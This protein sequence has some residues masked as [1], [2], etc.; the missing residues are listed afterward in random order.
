MDSHF[1]LLP[2]KNEGSP[3][4]IAEAA[5]YGVIPITSNVG[6]ISHY[7]NESNGFVWDI[8]GPQTY[9]AVFSKAI[10]LQELDLEF[11]SKNLEEVAEL[12]TYE[13]YINKLKTQIFD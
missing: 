6:S 11:R 1:L 3:K 5:C 12:F 10:S 9:E 13:N 4:V 8:N 7:I 2:S